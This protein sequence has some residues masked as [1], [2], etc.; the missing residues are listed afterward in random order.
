[1]RKHRFEETKVCRKES[2]V[3]AKEVNEI[4]FERLSASP[5]NKEA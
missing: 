4:G 2:F 1:M 3:V 5:K